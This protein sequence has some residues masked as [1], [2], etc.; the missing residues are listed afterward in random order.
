MLER[1]LSRENLIQALE[2]V[3]KNKGSYGVDEMDVK[4]L[5][6][7]LH[8]NWTSI[9]N[10]IIEGSYFPK[11]VRRVEIP[12]P[13]GGVRKLGI[14]TVMDRFLQQAIA[15]IL[16][17]LYDPTFSE[18]SF[19]F[20]P[21]RRGHNAVRQAKQWMKEG[22]RWVVDIDLEKFFDK[23]NHDRLMRKLSS[24]IQ[25]PRVL[26]LIRRYLQTG[27]MERGLVSPN[28]EG[29]PQ[30]GPL[31]PLLSNIVLDELDNELEKRGLKF[32]RYADDCNIYVRSKRAGLRIMESVTSFIENRLKLKVNREKSAVDRPW[33]RK[34]LGFSFT[35]GKDPKMRV[36]KESVKR[37]KQRIRELTSRRHSMKMSDRLRRLNRYLTGWLGYYQL[38]D[39][40]SI[41]AQIDAWIRRRLRMIRWKE[42]KTTSARQKNLVRL[43]IKKAKA[44]QWANSRK[45]YWRVAHSPI[46]D[47]ALNSEYWKGQGLMS[48]AERYQTRR[49]T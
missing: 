48:L 37:L 24:R 35:R 22:Y 29:T 12:K 39:T 7:H 38:V 31:S 13:N 40:P 11:P 42:W 1:I 14:P 33:N 10:E 6:L 17:Q 46:M 27:V 20:R 8:E 15:Q 32:V 19:G 16:T 21:H 5:R 9:R 47:Y 36:S 49:W 3:E 26:Q 44:W 45:G 41:L 28:T 23:V 30:G 2:R 4:S 43:G 34:F 18:R 25:D